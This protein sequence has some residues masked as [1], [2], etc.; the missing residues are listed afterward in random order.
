MLENFRKARQVNL[1]FCKLDGRESRITQKTGLICN[2][3]MHT[4]LSSDLH[5]ATDLEMTGNSNLS[6][7][8]IVVA[9]MCRAGKTCLCCRHIILAHRNVVSHLNQVVKFCALPD[10]C[11]PECSTVYRSIGTNLYII[12]YNDIAYL[13]NFLIAAVGLGA[14]PKPSAPITAPAWMTQR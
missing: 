6:A 8:H 14:N 1:H 11:A 5:T 10:F 3:G 12:F 13:R 4:A 7:K 2:I 9:N